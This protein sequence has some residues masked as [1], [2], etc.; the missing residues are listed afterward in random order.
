MN[1]PTTDPL[2]QRV[3]EIS[4]II[5]CLYRFSNATRNP[6]P[7]DRLQRCSSID[8]SAYEFFDLQHISEKLPAL[9]DS[10]LV[11]RLGRANTKRRQLLEYHRRH[12][13][14]IAYYNDVDD[15]GEANLVGGS[16]GS[17]HTDMHTTVSTLNQRDLEPFD[18]EDDHLDTRSELSQTSF[19][20][21]VGSPIGLRVPDP[22]VA[23]NEIPFECPYCFT[24]TTARNRGGWK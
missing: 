4:R 18:L 14:K 20:S 21:S 12:H 9:G 24:I 1:P 7:T 22:L 13:Q 17:T 3:C 23:F 6:A 16:T 15:T 8:V 5:T 10:Y 2:D 19:A 11:E